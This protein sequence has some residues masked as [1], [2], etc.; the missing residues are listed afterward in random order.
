MSNGSIQ[1]RKK[2]G[3]CA[4]EERRA[5]EMPKKRQGGLGSDAQGQRAVFAFLKKG[6][7]SE[8]ADEMG[9][10]ACEGVSSRED[11]WAELHLSSARSWPL[12]V[13]WSAGD[14][15]SGK[16]RKW[17]GNLEEGGIWGTS[18][19]LWAAQIAAQERRG[20]WRW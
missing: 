12:R 3:Y 1:Y 2:N 7:E 5:E 16:K 9:G 14:G 19:A 15:D 11:S 20:V 6:G 13:R 8:G 4:R 18:C 17:E 10:A